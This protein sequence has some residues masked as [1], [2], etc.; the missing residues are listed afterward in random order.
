MHICNSS[1]LIFKGEGH[2]QEHF[3]AATQAR[4]IKQKFQI[5]FWLLQSSRTLEPDMQ[6]KKVCG[7]SWVVS[8][9]DMVVK[10][11]I[12]HNTFAVMKESYFL[13]VGRRSRTPDSVAGKVLEK[14]VTEWTS[15]LCLLNTITRRRRSTSGVLLGQMTQ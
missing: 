11:I 12:F 4:C 6:Q 8:G 7:N 2:Q 5:T 3:E 10:L 14:P 1:E 15:R 9:S 13:F